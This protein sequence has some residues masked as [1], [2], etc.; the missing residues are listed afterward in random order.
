[1]LLLGVSKPLLGSALAKHKSGKHMKNKQKKSLRFVRR[2]SVVCVVA[3][4]LL[5][6]ALASAQTNGLPSM[7]DATGGFDESSA[8]WSGLFVGFIAGA[9][10]WIFRIVRQVSN[11]NP[12][13]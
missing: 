2:Y 10:A 4:C 3:A 7:P 13:I 1:M 5:L 9:T 11:Q 12:E 8:F 6:P